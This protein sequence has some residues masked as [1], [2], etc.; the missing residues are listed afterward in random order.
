MMHWVGD[1]H[2]SVLVNGCAMMNENKE[3]YRLRLGVGQG[4]MHRMQ[5]ERSRREAC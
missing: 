2:W 1:W 4:Q 3:T 5:L